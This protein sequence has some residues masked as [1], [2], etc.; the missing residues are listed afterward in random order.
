MSNDLDT[1]AP[2]DDE[3]ED[4]PWQYG[5]AIRQAYWEQVG[6][7]S[8]MAFFGPTNGPASPW[9]GQAE[10]YAPVWTQDSTIITTDGMSSPWS[11]T[12]GDPGEGLEYYIDSPRL[13]GAGLEDLQASWE[14]ELLIRVVSTYAGQGY[15][16]TFDH[17]GCLT[18]RVPEVDVPADWLDDEGH[19]CL[20]LGAPAGLR[21]D[22]V[23]MYSDPQ[24]VR[25]VALTPLRPEEID[26]VVSEGHRSVAGQVL[27]DSEY[28]NQVRLDRP[29]LLEPMKAAASAPGAQH[30]EQ[31]PPAQAPEPAPESGLTPEPE[32][33]PESGLTPEPEPRPEPAGLPLSASRPASAPTPV[34]APT[35]PEPEPSS[36]GQPEPA[37]PGQTGPS[38]EQVPAEAR[39]DEAPP[40]AVLPVAPV[41]ELPWD[42]A[43]V[44]SRIEEHLRE[45][46][47]L[48]P[49]GVGLPVTDEHL[50]RFAGVLP[51]SVLHV[52]RRFG[53][54]GFGQGRTWVTDPLRWAPVVEAWLDGVDLPFDDQGWWCLTRTALGG[55]ALWGEV[56]GPVLE[57]DP[58]S[59]VV[60]V[61][62]P[63]AQHMGS[64]VMRERMGALLLVDPME[65]FYEDEDSERDLID[66]AVEVLGPVGPDEVYGVTPPGAPMTRVEVAALSVQD[67]AEHL[68]DRARSVE[69]RL[70]ADGLR[71]AALRPPAPSEEQPEDQPAQEGPT[72]P[73]AHDESGSA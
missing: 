25:L 52:W 9:P 43:W 72:A 11:D 67:A 59:A 73:E 38:P 4:Y 49:L 18:L 17:H 56:S 28:R 63:A 61:H 54:E 26:W 58:L 41:E 33:A 48:A 23:E 30:P 39:P 35:A 36:P 24:A 57:I 20:L 60:R 65:D 29:S 10:N 46:A 7:T 21:S 62:P 51:D 50:E 2:R 44:D 1:P 71:A 19:L 70:E 27:A 6:T 12:G 45:E 14:L 13:K 55:M 22:Y 40:S 69:R 37:S 15:R 31:Q 16:P 34:E 47:G 3:T 32:P 42:L 8:D 5:A 53:F 68:I 66:V 64:R